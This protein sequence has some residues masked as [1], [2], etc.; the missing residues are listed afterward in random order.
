[1]DEKSLKFFNKEI[2]TDFFTIDITDVLVNY[3]LDL[4]VSAP[5]AEIQIQTLTIPHFMQSYPKD[6]GPVFCLSGKEQI[7]V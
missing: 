6:E 4:F 2:V 5:C 7:K 3:I 1:M